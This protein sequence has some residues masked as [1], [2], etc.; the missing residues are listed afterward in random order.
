MLYNNNYHKSYCELINT[1]KDYN[2]YISRKNMKYLVDLAN[3]EENINPITR[4]ILFDGKRAI[5]TDQIIWLEEKSIQ[6]MLREPILIP[7]DII[8]RALNIY[9]FLA[10]TPTTV[11]GILIVGGFY[12]EVFPRCNGSEITYR[13]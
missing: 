12:H 13:S 8:I 1:M 3:R 7:V 11:N 6:P 4:Q 10:V 5:A 2:G 9:P